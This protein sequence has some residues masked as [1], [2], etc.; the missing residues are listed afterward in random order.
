MSD[1]IEPTN[2]KDPKKEKEKRKNHLS[3]QRDDDCYSSTQSWHKNSRN[4]N[5]EKKTIYLFYLKIP[6]DDATNINDPNLKV[7]D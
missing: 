4:S 7:I 6:Q 3:N 2:S 1:T 5:S